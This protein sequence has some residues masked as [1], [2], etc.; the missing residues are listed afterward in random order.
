MWTRKEVF[1]MTQHEVLA[2]VDGLEKF[3]EKRAG[4]R[5]WPSRALLMENLNDNR[6]FWGPD[7]RGEFYDTERTLRRKGWLVVE[8][9]SHC[10]EGSHVRLTAAGAQAL[11]L[12]DEQGCKSHIHVKR[13][14][15]CHVENF[16]FRAKIAA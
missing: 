11:R 8:T 4:K 3:I 2:F 12:M 7:W 9:C 6:Q 1:P 16:G 14:E 10:G 15:H 13:R 5:V